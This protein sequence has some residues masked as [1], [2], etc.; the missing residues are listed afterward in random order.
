MEL[1]DRPAVSSFM[2][3]CHPYYSIGI[4][5]ILRFPVIIDGYETMES[6][7]KFMF[8][9]LMGSPPDRCRFLKDLEIKRDFPRGPKEVD[10]I[11]LSNFLHVISHSICLER[12]VLHRPSTL[13]RRFDH[14]VDTLASLTALRE[15]DCG[16]APEVI[17][18][19]RKLRAPLTKLSFHVYDDEDPPVNL[20]STIRNFNGTLCQLFTGNISLDPIKTDIQFL[21]LTVLVLYEIPSSESFAAST[22]FRFF[23][24]LKDLEFPRNYDDSTTDI[25]ES[26]IREDYQASLRD[27][28]HGNSV[29][30]QSLDVLRGCATYMFRGGWCCPV[31]RLIV[32][33]I[34]H[35]TS[36]WLVPLLVPMQPPD[37]V[38]IFALRVS[39]LDAL[40]S[41]PSIIQELSITGSLKSLTLVFDL[42]ATKSGLAI[43]LLV[44]F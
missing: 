18:W 8:S 37:V 15:I 19:L 22:I 13:F 23:P 39:G 6:F 43:K 26:T 10:N 35:T 33:S 7:H 4:P 36:Q 42:T 14:A 30:H 21:N 1:L 16:N 27:A 24:N 3:T 32:D 11:Y 38:L 34:D 2:K 5:G 12:I 17:D 25:P 31:K 28:T 41:L 20:L 44:R 9:T 40:T 29:A